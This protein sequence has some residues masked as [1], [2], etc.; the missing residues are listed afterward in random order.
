MINAVN[1]QL[2]EKAVEDSKRNI[3]FLN[4]ELASINNIELTENIYTLIQD[5]TNKMMIASTREEYA[6]NIIDPAIPPDLRYSPKRRILV[7]SAGLIS[8]FVSMFP[9]Y[10]ILLPEST[11]FSIVQLL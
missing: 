6:F 7:M 8:V 10:P 4:E 5:E 9:D 3:L 2:Q 1:I 11:F